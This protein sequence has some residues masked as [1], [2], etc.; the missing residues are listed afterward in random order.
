MDGSR[1]TTGLLAR[2]GAALLLAGGAVLIPA[3]P[4]AAEEPVDFGATDIVDTAEVLSAAD[5]A[6][7][8]SALDDLQQSTGVTLLVA[9]VD[10]AENP[11]DMDDWVQAVADRNGLGDDNALLAVAVDQSQYR[12]TVDAE[13]AVTDAELEDIRRSDIVPALGEGD[14]VGAVQGAANGLE[15]YLVGS[16]TSGGGAAPGFSFNPLP[17]ILILGGL[18]LVLVI[19][20]RVLGARRRRAALRKQEEDQKQLDVRAGGL[21]VE[22]DDALKTSEQELGF[23]EA[24]FGAEQTAAFRAAVGSAQEKVREAFRIKQRLDD[25]EPETPE[26]RRELSGRIIELCEQA[27]AELD[28]QAEEFDRLRE[29]GRRAPEALATMTTE[30]ERIG[31]RVPAAEAALTALRRRFDASA[32]ADV[33][34]NPDQARKLLAFA[35]GEGTEAAEAIRGGH[36]AAAAVAVRSAQ[37]ALDQ[38]THLLD[39]VERAGT[40][41]DTALQQLDGEIAD[42]RSDV[43]EARAVTVPSPELPQL[44]AQAEQAIAD[45]SSGAPRRDPVAAVG[46]LT[47]LEQRVDAALGPAREAAQRRQ[48]AE[49]ALGRT[50]SAARAQV[51]GAKEYIL[52]RRGGVGTDA[53]TRATEAERRLAAAEQL[54][55]ADPEAAL[56]EAQA[57]SSLAV[58]A[59]NFARSDVDGFWSAGGGSGFGTGYSGGGYRG[60]RGGDDITGAI[61]GGIIGGMLGGGGSRGGG[62]GGGVRWGG[63]GGGFSG[64]SRSRG[65]GGGFGGGRSFGGSGR[66]GGGGRF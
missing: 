25:A 42:L 20:F 53:R 48:R 46:T 4:A 32:I 28:A 15:R 41:L 26:Q 17:T 2:A 24:E 55:N 31:A 19:V 54:R 21:L 5:E 35:A 36:G 27:D 7:M 61:L 37:Q 38:A 50:L 11:A 22:L 52:T 60:G 65:G 33:A 3:L 1:R 23:A 13:M 66:R 44:V 6:T 9:F 43:A 14:W 58:S 62:Y 39:A 63:G 34:D 18:I 56:V 29:L 51:A 47:A 16:G 8:E 57:A 59:L 45:A 40:D 30:A 12:F 49:A 10:T 64:S